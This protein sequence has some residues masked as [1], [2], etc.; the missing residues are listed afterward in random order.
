MIL[1]CSF[2]SFEEAFFTRPSVVYKGSIM[3]WSNLSQMRMGKLSQIRAQFYETQNSIKK[4]I[5]EAAPFL[6]GVLEVDYRDFVSFNG[7][8]HERGIAIPNDKGTELLE[9]INSKVKDFLQVNFGEAFDKSVDFHR[10]ECPVVKCK[11]IL[12]ETE[13]EDD[14]VSIPPLATSNGCYGPCGQEWII[15]ALFPCRILFEASQCNVP[16]FTFLF[17][18]NLHIQLLS[19]SYG[20]FGKISDKLEVVAQHIDDRPCFGSVYTRSLAEMLSVSKPVLASI[21]DT[22]ARDKLL[23]FGELDLLIETLKGCQPNSYY[24][25]LWASDARLYESNLDLRQNFECHFGERKSLMDEEISDIDVSDLLLNDSD[26][27]PPSQE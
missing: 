20:A 8:R 21:P 27:Q 26:D 16:D 13:T 10:E 6:G 3:D 2:P 12:H 22:M 14:K 25:R 7:P 23:L 19:R 4:E 17:P 18:G 11:L 24:L 9:N 5:V 15:S 1:T